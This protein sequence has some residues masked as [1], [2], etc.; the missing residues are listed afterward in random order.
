[1]IKGTVA[2]LERLN[3]IANRQKRVRF[4]VTIVQPSISKANVSEDILLLL[5]FPKNLRFVIPYIQSFS[6]RGG[7]NK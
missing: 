3:R 6:L 2:D 1:M 7:Q 4:E 5:P